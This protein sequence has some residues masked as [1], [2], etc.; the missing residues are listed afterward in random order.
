[1]EKLENEKIQMEQQNQFLL[2]RL[3]QMEAENN[4]LNRQ[5]AQLSAEVR[6]SRGNTPKPSSPTMTS[7]TLTPTLFKQEGDDDFPL[8]RVRFPTP[9]AT[10]Y[11]P[12]L[13]PSTLV[14]SSDV[15]QHPA[16]VLC[17]LQ[18]Q[19]QDSKGL[20]ARYHSL[21]SDQAM[22]LY[23]QTMLQLLYL[24]MT[25]AA[26]S[27]VIH[28]L[29]RIL[30]SL[31][32]GSPL[33]F[34]TEEIYRHFPLIQW[35]ILTPTLS[36]SKASSRPPVFRMRLLA[37]LLACS[38][39]LARPLRDATGRALQQAVRERLSEKAR[40]VAD[41]QGGRQSWESLLTLAW[42]VD[43]LGQPGHTKRGVS[44]GSRSTHDGWRKPHRSTR[45]S[46]SSNSSKFRLMGKYT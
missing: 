43:H 40:S 27:A 6:G 17:G 16:A 34:S 12:T 25:S 22:N 10:E 21:T 29:S 13:K 4:R 14:E 42:A 35:L 11:S 18:C 28:P 20:E 37:R 38:P 3:T 32:T 46:W 26:Y 2:Q 30:L 8:E 5:V 24:T 23:L 41:V 45:G 15:T 44:N 9:S 39:A 7:P 36:T 33:T 31:K 1:M 19:S